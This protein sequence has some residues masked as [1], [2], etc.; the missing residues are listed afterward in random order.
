MLKRR[1]VVPEE[2]SGLRL[3]VLGGVVVAAISIGVFGGLPILAALCVPVTAA[4]HYWSW[5]SRQRP[6]QWVRA[7]VGL[8]LTG[9][10]LLLL[11][12]LF[13]GV[14]ADPFPQGSFLLLLMAITSFDVRSR[15]NC[16]SSLVFGL[17]GL[18]AAA[19]VAYDATMALFAVAFA[20]AVLAAFALAT[21]AD[22][23]R[24]TAAVI[25]AQRPP[26]AE[27]AAAPASRPFRP[28][29]ALAT[30]CGVVLSCAVATY[31]VVPAYVGALPIYPV[32]ADL[33]ISQSFTGEVLNPVLP[34][35]SLRGPNH[36]RSG[37]YGFGPELR[38]G[39][40]G[41]L[42]AT[43]VMRVRSTGWSYW[44]M[45]TFDRYTG[46]SWRTANGLLN[47]L[48]RGPDGAMEPAIYPFDDGEYHAPGNASDAPTAT[49]RQTFTLAQPG[50]NLIAAAY[51][52][53]RLYFPST[54]V[55]QRINADDLIADQPLPAGATY[56][57]VSQ[58]PDTTPALLRAATGPDP[59]F[60]TADD[61][62]LPSLPASLTAVART[63]IAGATTRYD[64]VMAVIAYL[65]S[66][67][68]YDLNTPALPPGAEG[69]TTLLSSGRGYC[70]AF[71]T[72][73]TVLARLNGIP[74]RLVTGFAPGE[75]NPLSHVYTVRASDAHAWTE[76]YFPGRGWLPFDATPGGAAQPRPHT[77]SA[78]LLG[79]LLADHP[80]PRLDWAGLA[81][82]SGAVASQSS[83]WLRAAAQ[84]AA[85]RP[86]APPLAILALLGVVLLLVARRA[87]WPAS[88]KA[89]GSYRQAVLASFAAAE[90]S[91]ARHGGPARAAAATPRRYAREVAALL[92]APGAAA[93]TQLAELATRA[94]YAGPEPTEADAR[95]ARLL[96]QELRRVKRK[97]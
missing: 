93:L 87:R 8:A 30:L 45:Q 28:L 69:V 70:E 9:A 92:P 60:A 66:H 20:V 94:A 21:R 1:P 53:I 68:R 88:R 17:L 97:Q 63:A 95:A 11:A 78:W 27:G 33:P 15:T 22:A 34:L 96:C 64:K 38:L 2:S 46:R 54:A 39:A 76:I 7:M 43:V 80:L 59:W 86:A 4:G 10:T 35:I 75:Y 40:Y 12:E 6:R 62:V 90:R 82:D 91:L 89:G 79:A 23:Q 37:Y 67:A 14:G 65:D 32:S 73:L 74:A 83:L 3:A 58:A 24:A 25:S 50:P 42:D 13:L 55:A 44:R 52:P 36:S 56:S 5:R 18:Y 84:W 48:E 47:Q 72:A 19:S 77:T 29:W 41:P 26:P 61:L 81:H 85:A 71:A 31:A 49:I 51:R 16:Y 57:V